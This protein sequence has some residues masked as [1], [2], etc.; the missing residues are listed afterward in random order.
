METSPNEIP[1]S[2]ELLIPWELPLDQHLSPADRT[3]IDRALSQLLQALENLSLQEALSHINHA[4]AELGE[5]DT[6][7]ASICNTKTSLK[8]W[9]VEDYDRYFQI[10]H[11]CTEQSALCL[12]QGLLVTCHQFVEI[13]LQTPWLD[14]QHIQQQKQGFISYIHLLRRIFDLNE[15]DIQKTEN[16]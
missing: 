14:V 7:T 16:S 15:T 8:A 6:Q 2:L 5:I 1:T 3:R 11:V 10:R 12:V 9:E 13:Y 4:L